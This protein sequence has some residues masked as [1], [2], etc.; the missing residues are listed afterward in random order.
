MTLRVTPD[1]PSRGVQSAPQL[2]YRH[3]LDGLRA[4]AVLLIVV[5][6]VWVGRVSGGVDVFL[7]LSAF[8]LTASFAKRAEA[9]G[10]IAPL[11]YWTKTFKRLLPAAAVVLLGVLVATA[12]LLP[13]TRWS[14]IWS[15]TV[16]SLF[17]FQNWELAATSVDYYAAHDALLSPLQHF[18]SMSIQGQIFVLWPLLI[19]GGTML[20]RRLGR[21][22]RLT[23]VA[24]FGV[25]FAASL[26]YSVVITAVNQQWAYFDT[27]ARLWEFALGSL[28]ALVLPFVRLP[29]P[30][31]AVLGWAGLAGI[32]LCGVLFDVQGGFPGYLALWPTMCAAM[33]I[34]AGSSPTSFGPDR[35][36]AFG[37][38]RW[39]G[40]SAYALY[41]VHWPILVFW[42]AIADQGDPG[43]IAGGV[44]ILASIVLAI[45]IHRLVERPLREFSWGNRT[46]RNG[47]AVIAASLALVVAPL[48]AWQF[49]AD[50]Q[51]DAIAAAGDHPGAL[52]L[53]PTVGPF[54][55]SS[56]PLPAATALDEEWVTLPESCSG[57][58]APR[59]ALLDDC[60]QYRP[61]GA[62]VATIAIVGDSHSEQ[63]MGALLPIAE[64]SSWRLVAVLKGGCSFGLDGK[65]PEWSEAALDYLLELQPDAVFTVGTAAEPDGRHE[66]LTPGFEDAASRLVDEGIDVIAV[67]DN[68]RFGFNVYECAIEA[69]DA[70]DDCSVA[71]RT[72]QPASNPLDAIGWMD[73]VY[74]VDLTEAICPGGRCM[75]EIGNVYV[76]LDDNHLTKTYAVSL[77]PVLER[78]LV[79]VIS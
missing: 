77:A 40:N 4:L 28:V 22:V 64:R 32:V 71:L 52:V 25:V 41:L 9:G 58:V 66:I 34:V 37:P 43:P 47:L 57:A 56:P 78:Q 55:A 79:G 54:E 35:L 70:L 60:S 29:E 42:I 26:S 53:D 31:R 6:H 65:C 17:Y 76:Y 18:W 72:V 7:M 27:G 50:A 14:S 21:S 13:E 30:V 38:L 45:V 19:I 2:R 51:A 8:F 24:V 49:Q 44:I 10:A 36:L 11:A 73:G 16:A 12:V 20:A 3:D 61:T 48:G 1:A 46:K 15:Q 33:L 69:V 62:P 23:L 39:L 59:D 5:Y 68:P 74:L 63:M 75:P 67:R